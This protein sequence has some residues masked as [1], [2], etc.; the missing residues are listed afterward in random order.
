M[1]VNG[2]WVIGQ[3]AIPLNKSCLHLYVD[4]FSQ[5]Q[6]TAKRDVDSRQAIKEMANRDTHNTGG[7][8]YHKIYIRQSFVEDKVDRNQNNI[9]LGRCWTI[10]SFMNTTDEISLYS[11][12]FHSFNSNKITSICFVCL[13]FWLYLCWKVPIHNLAYWFSSFVWLFSK[14]VFSPLPIEWMSSFFWLMKNKMPKEKI[15]TKIN[16]TVCLFSCNYKRS[17]ECQ[18]VM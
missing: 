14:D 8:Q 2:D 17:I 16:R 6:G 13:R 15:S 1:C 12:S 3:L 5:R 11:A 10:R 4:H 7:N 18:C 9:N